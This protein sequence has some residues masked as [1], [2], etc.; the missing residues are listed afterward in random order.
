VKRD[1]HLHVRASVMRRGARIKLSKYMSYL[2]RHH[3][4]KAGLSLDEEGFVLIDDL[5]EA[6]SSNP[7]WSWVTR[8]H[9]IQ[10]VTGDEKGRFQVV[11]EKIRAAYGH[12][13]E[14]RPKY[15]RIK[16]PEILYHGTSRRAVP[17]IKRE[18]LKPLKR[19]YVH[20][21]PDW[22][23]AFDVGRRHDEEPVVLEIRARDAYRAGI[24]FTRAAP[25]VYLSDPI[26]PEFIV[27]PED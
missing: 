24:F 2:L 1:T 18:G 10:V 20:L 7:R 8:H 5:V 12:S 27:F 14:V 11:G 15:E 3:P 21:S 25:K 23:T 6:I 16:P 19:R 22:D 17:Q 13:V 4:E 9:V 26:P